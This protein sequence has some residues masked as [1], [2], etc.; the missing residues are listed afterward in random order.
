VL[1]SAIEDAL[2]PDGEGSHVL[3]RYEQC[4]LFMAMEKM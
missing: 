4:F 1:L 2:R 3:F